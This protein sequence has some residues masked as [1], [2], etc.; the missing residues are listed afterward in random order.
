MGPPL[1]IFF[2]KGAVPQAVHKAVPVL[3]HWHEEVR[4]ELERDCALGIL[5]KME[6]NTPAEWCCRMVCVPIRE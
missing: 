5:E 1:K 4:Q 3:I 2:R 6:V